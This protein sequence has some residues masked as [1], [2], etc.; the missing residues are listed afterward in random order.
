MYL[1]WEYQQRQTGQEFELSEQK[2]LP[3]EPTIPL[4]LG[5]AATHL[6]FR[7]LMAHI[8]SD[9]ATAEQRQLFQVEVDRATA[10]LNNLRTQYSSIAF[11]ALGMGMDVADPMAQMLAEHIRVF[12]ALTPLVKSTA[13]GQTYPRQLKG[14]AAYVQWMMTDTGRAAFQHVAAAKEQEPG[15]LALWY[16][17]VSGQD[18]LQHPPTQPPPPGQPGTALDKPLPAFSNP[19]PE[20]Q[21]HISEDP[22]P[23]TNPVVWGGT[24]RAPSIAHFS[25][26]DCRNLA[27]RI[28][29]VPDDRLDAAEHTLRRYSRANIRFR[30]NL[31]LVADVSHIP[32]SGLLTN[33]REAVD[34]ILEERYPPRKERPAHGRESRLVEWPRSPVAFGYGTPPTSSHQLLMD[35]TTFTTAQSQPSPAARAAAAARRDLDLQS[36][37]AGFKTQPLRRP[38]PRPQREQEPDVEGRFRESLRRMPQPGAV[39]ASGD[40]ARIQ[41]L[42]EALS[43]SGS[44]GNRERLLGALAPELRAELARGMLWSEGGRGGSAGLEGSREGEDGGGYQGD[45]ALGEAEGRV[46]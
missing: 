42:Q 26:D 41:A 9:N 18:Q 27:V 44:T 25:A 32:T 39:V 35:P 33:F 6:G 28:L 16:P 5:R 46:E 21:T 4:L 37:P 43:D 22:I 19:F 40:L 12:P 30:Q 17:P 2:P 23:Q 7:A 36:M 10:F 13:A 11:G 8:A 14:F 34:G 24:N 1:Q 38:P 15:P 29:D 20:R 3:V 45:E 31:K